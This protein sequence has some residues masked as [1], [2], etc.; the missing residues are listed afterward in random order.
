MQTKNRWQSPLRWALIILL[1][2]L[3]VSC[4]RVRLAYGFLDNWLRWQTA[5]YVTL[6]SQQQQQ[7]TRLTKEF[8]RWH[9]A[10]ELND[11]AHLLDATVTT[12]AG[13]TIST[14]DLTAAFS[15]IGQLWQRT[16]ARLIP[17]AEAILATLSQEQIDQIVTQLQ[18]ESGDF[19]EEYVALSS[20]EIPRKRAEETLEN[21]ESVLGKLTPAQVDTVEQW[22]RGQA[23]L[24]VL[25]LQQQRIWQ[26][27]FE[28][29]LRTDLSEHD[30][31]RRAARLIFAQ[32]EYLSREHERL[33]TNN[34]QAWREMIVTIHGS[35]TE[36]QKKRLLGRL[37]GYA[38][39]FR[40]L[41]GRAE[42]AS[43]ISRIETTAPK[44]PLAR[45]AAE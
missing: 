9:Q 27:Q 10:H 23:S 42:Q 14:E 44:T 19:Q 7:L 31:L 34:R 29:A 37:A 11:Y 39:D 43:A 17:I 35:L 4:S 15:E 33:T 28:Q 26:Y 2:T 20:D 3:L 18:K 24:A 38:S 25:T 32:P 5:N 16:E 30:N 45:A 1:T 22:A 36:A 6:D 13:E 21:L 40:Y 8:Q 12:F 41:A